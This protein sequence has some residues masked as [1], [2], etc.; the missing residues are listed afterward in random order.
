[1]L[2]IS[3]VV[4]KFVMRPLW[5]GR[6]LRRE[7]EFLAFQCDIL[8]APALA[9]GLVLV[10]AMDDRVYLRADNPVHWAI[11]AA[12]VGLGVAHYLQERKFYSWRQMTTITKIYH[13]LL[14]PFVGYV[15]TLVGVYGLIF[16]PWTQY[17][18][19]MRVIF[20]FCVGAWALAWP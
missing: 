9:S 14:F 20:V 16:A 10:Q 13:E 12:A 8:F 4:I 1:M 7:D 3:P 5:E 6:I 11:L 2:C 17:M 18:V 15:L 19:G